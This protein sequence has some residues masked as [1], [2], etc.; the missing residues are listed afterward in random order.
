MTIYFL[1]G[2]TGSGKS[3]IG[4][5]LERHNIVHLDGDQYITDE[6]RSCLEKDEQMTPQMIDRYVVHLER[7][8]KA[9]ALEGKNM[10]VTQALYLDKHRQYLLKKIPDLTFVWLKSPAEL[11]SSRITQRFQQGESKVTASYAKEMDTFFEPPTHQHLV[12]NNSFASFNDLLSHLEE[13]LSD[14]FVTSRDV[15]MACP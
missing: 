10:L 8:I 6:M 11:R 7:V 14:V 5:L 12:L 3:Y 15:N 9:K 2:K 4:N 1:F 13:V